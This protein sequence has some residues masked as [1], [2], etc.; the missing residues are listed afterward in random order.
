MCSTLSYNWRVPNIYNN[1]SKLEP[2][3]SDQIVTQSKSDQGNQG[4]S[5][6]QKNVMQGQKLHNGKQTYTTKNIK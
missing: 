5:S 6:N 1:F 3:L 4:Y 2:P